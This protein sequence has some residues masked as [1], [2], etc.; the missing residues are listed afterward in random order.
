MGLAREGHNTGNLI[1][2]FKVHFPEKLE[3]E[4]IVKLREA[5]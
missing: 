5:L 1:I 4:Q 3:E 2:H